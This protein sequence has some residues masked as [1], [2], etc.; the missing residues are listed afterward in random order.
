M[1]FLVSLI[2]VLFSNIGFSA[3]KNFEIGLVYGYNDQHPDPYVI[4]NFQL[5]KLTADL[6]KPCQRTTELIC[7]FQLHPGHVPTLIRKIQN[8]QVSVYPLSSSYTTY[9][10][11]NRS[12][13]Y[14]HQQA[15][16]SYQTKEFFLTSLKH[17]HTTFYIGHARYGSG[18][19]FFILP[20]EKIGKKPPKDLSAINEVIQNVSE[21]LLQPHVYLLACDS[22]LHWKARLNLRRNK[23]NQYF[24]LNSIIKPDQVDIL[25]RQLLERYLKLNLLNITAPLPRGVVRL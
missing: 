8:I 12:L 11:T 2:I 23:N 3:V 10:P 22:E 21:N 14:A 24:V 16:K 6:T 17:F 1:N 13:Q 15:A 9:D 4:D 5:Q 7:G 18:P 25:T 19:D 20:Q